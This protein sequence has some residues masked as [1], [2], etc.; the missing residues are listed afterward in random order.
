MNEQDKMDLVL[1]NKRG[2]KYRKQKTAEAIGEIYPLSK[3]KSHQWLDL[4]SV[5]GN[6]P[7][8]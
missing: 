2:E 6:R 4:S 5:K 1:K 8:R 7:S 3:D